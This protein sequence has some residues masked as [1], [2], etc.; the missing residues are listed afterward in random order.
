[1]SMPPNSRL[2][3]GYELQDT[4]FRNH[5][6]DLEGTPKEV[7]VF[8]GAQRITIEGGSTTIRAGLQMQPIP[9]PAASPYAYPYVSSNPYGPSWGP[10]SAPLDTQLPQQW[11]TPLP[12]DQ[13]PIQHQT[14]QYCAEQENPG[15]LYAGIAHK[16]GTSGISFPET[17]NAHQFNQGG[18]MKNHTVE[19]LEDVIPPNRPSSSLAHH[20]PAT[21]LHS[22][23]EPLGPQGQTHPNRSHSETEPPTLPSH[24]EGGE[25]DSKTIGQTPAKP[26]KKR[27]KVKKWIRLKC[28]LIISAF[29]R[30][31]HGRS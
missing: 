4:N 15:G 16:E 19:G 5:P 14:L 1:M 21:T 17:N 28:R 10:A 11:M 29:K 9:H 22:Q 8:H 31:G 23:S 3:Y 25:S 27:S 18:Y 20:H 13:V 12:A 24:I 6:L 2:E 7:S 26:Q 30:G